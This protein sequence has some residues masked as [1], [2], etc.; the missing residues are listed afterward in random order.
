MNTQAHTIPM[1]AEERAMPSYVRVDITEFKYDVNGNTAAKHFVY[2][3]NAAGEKS[4]LLSNT[5][6][7]RMQT[8]VTDRLD[9]LC[10][11]V[12]RAGLDF[13]NYEQ[14]SLTGS[15]EDGLITVLLHRAPF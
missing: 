14:L 5:T 3:S 10:T 9:Y 8:G 11:A 12:R 13:T 2:A 6:P 1:S 15:R 7:R 4:R